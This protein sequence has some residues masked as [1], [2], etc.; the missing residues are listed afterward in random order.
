[1]NMNYAMQHDIAYHVAHSNAT[2]ESTHSLRSAFLLPAWTT[3]NWDTIDVQWV[4]N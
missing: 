3:D 4:K 2:R 1:M